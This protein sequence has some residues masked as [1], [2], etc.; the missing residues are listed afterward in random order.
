MSSITVS[1]SSIKGR[2]SPPPSKSEAHRA[3]IC[4]ALAGGDS[5]H[6]VSDS[7][8]MRA[9]LGAIHALGV[10]TSQTGD[11]V[12]I[13]Q[14]PA[15][16]D[17]R[18]SSPVV[19]CLESGSTLRFLL[20]ICAA[21]GLSCIFTGCGRL[22]ERPLG[23]YA[24]CLPPH[25]VTLKKPDSD[26]TGEGALPLEI[27]GKLEAGRY[28]L[29][30]NVS[31]QF[32]SGLLF[33]LPLCDGNSEIVLTTP[34]ESAAYVEMTIDALRSAGIDVE[35]T[36]NGWTVPGGQTYR[37]HDYEIEGDWSQAAF[38]LAMGALGGE[39]TVAG[40]NRQS[41]QGD[42]A[43]FDLL[44]RFGGNITETDG[45][46]LCRK[47]ALH[48]IAIDASQIP[49]LVP[50]LAVLGALAEGTTTIT[51]AA[52]LR[53]KESD[54]LA[55]TADNL[56]LLGAKVQ[57]TPDGLILEGVPRLH[58]GVTLPG[59]NDH[60]IVMSMAAAALGCENPIVLGG[61]ECVAKSW[62]SF[63]DEYKTCGGEAYVIRHRN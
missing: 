54:R 22:P 21:K 42:R 30:G 5:V 25:G 28:E 12:I 1:P 63:F 56:R 32:I 44:H 20:P 60:R 10:E 4:A 16:E 53:L 9:T 6:G 57:E 13:R 33:A 52:R 45:G 24:D 35:P 34:L 48:G 2:L 3:L 8:D 58:G 50:I 17:H 36:P 47:S 55:A 37:P 19:N 14:R 38:L 18:L 7:D 23:V 59:Y 46:V 11:T 39:I 27:E 40:M 51:G 31:S 41:R 61:A 62:P 29:P 26:S 49:D 43:I 15:S